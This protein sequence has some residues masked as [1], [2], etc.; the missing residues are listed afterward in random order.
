MLVG[1][2]EIAA[3]ISFHSNN[4]LFTDANKH[5]PIDGHSIELRLFPPEKELE[6]TSTSLEGRDGGAMYDAVVHGH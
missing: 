5:C 3:A 2:K 4:C 6:Y 1:G